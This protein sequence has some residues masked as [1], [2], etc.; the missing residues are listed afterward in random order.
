M[1]GYLLLQENQMQPGRA[2]GFA[3]NPVR[4]GFLDYMRELRQESFSFPEGHK[5][6]VV[7]LEEVLIA[8]G[9]QREEVAAFIHH[10][11]ASR[12]NELNAYRI[13]V[14]IVFR[15]SLMSANDFWFELG[16]DKRIS[17]RRIFDTPPLQCDPAGNEYYY[18]GFN[19]S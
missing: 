14:Q 17:I 12:A 7:G 1:A 11:L 18:V 16:G 13:N 2:K 8:A 9:E 3:R 4:M 6:M 19:L 5:L 15:R 10:T